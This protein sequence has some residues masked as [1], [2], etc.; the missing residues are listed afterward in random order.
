MIR[1]LLLAVAFAATLS[2]AALAQDGGAAPKFST[3]TT[4]V[5]DIMA[6]PEAKAAFTKVLPELATNEQLSQGYEFT[7]A[8]IAE[9][10]YADAAKFKELD[11]EFAK[12][13]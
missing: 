12:I 3:A 4:K 7:L 8:Q 2:P 9:F 13:K 11:A 1:K 5:A 10:G 6:N